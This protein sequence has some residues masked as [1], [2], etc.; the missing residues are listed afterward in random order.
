MKTNTHYK[1]I[2]WRNPSGLH[3]DIGMSISELKF[4]QDE[5]H[6]LRDL[7][8]EDTLEL[9]YNITHEKAAQIAIA[10]R[11]YDKRVK[12]LLKEMQAHANNLQ[13]LIDDIDVPNE[14]KEYKNTHYELMISTMDLHADVK[15]TKRTIFKML[16]EIMKKS[17]QKNLH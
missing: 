6:F 1:Y 11:G 15:K 12:R 14:V 7:V 10:L 3:D 2:E 16:A 17:K 9:I 8:A 13:V 5:L 4:L